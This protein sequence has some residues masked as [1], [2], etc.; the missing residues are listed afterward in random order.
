M[1]GRLMHP[2]LEE[3]FR[4]PFRGLIRRWRAGFE[5]RDLDLKT[6]FGI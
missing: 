5:K 1:W 6:V 2:R 3:G 4:V